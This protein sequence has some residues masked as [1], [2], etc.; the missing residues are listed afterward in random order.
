MVGSQLVTQLSSQREAKINTSCH[1]SVH[2]HRD[3]TSDRK[4]KSHAIATLPTSPCPPHLTPKF[5]RNTKQRLTRGHHDAAPPAHSTPDNNSLPPTQHDPPQT[6]PMDLQTLRVPTLACPVSWS[7]SA[8]RDSNIR[9][10][11]LLI[12][13]KANERKCLPLRSQKN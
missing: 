4:Y 3:N 2:A 9:V 12:T 11:S 13:T 10:S 1:V 5:D 7:P 6:P 8:A